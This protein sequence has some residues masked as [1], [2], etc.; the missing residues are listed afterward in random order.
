MG[1]FLFILNLFIV[2]LYL[3]KLKLVLIFENLLLVHFAELL[4]SFYVKLLKGLNILVWFGYICSCAQLL[5]HIDELRTISVSFFCSRFPLRM[6][7]GQPS[8]FHTLSQEKF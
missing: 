6:R 3:F 8:Q 5:L 2:I 4:M 7:C 1:L